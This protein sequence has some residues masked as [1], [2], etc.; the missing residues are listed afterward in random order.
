[1]AIQR[2]VEE[3]QLPHGAPRPG[4]EPSPFAPPPWAKDTGRWGWIIIAV[5]LVAVCAFVVVALTKLIVLAALF[6]VLIGG[7]FLPVVDWLASG[8]TSNAG[9]RRS[10]WSSF[11]SSS[12]SASASWSC[13]A[14]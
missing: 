8:I 13:T 11:S 4:D 10:L 14:S 7:T 12:P 9:S 5:I 6:A 3:D 1:M 2:P